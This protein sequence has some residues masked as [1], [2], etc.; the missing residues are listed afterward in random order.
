MGSKKTTVEM[1]VQTEELLRAHADILKKPH[2]LFGYL[3]TCN[4]TGM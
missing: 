4:D 1:L 2:V 3:D